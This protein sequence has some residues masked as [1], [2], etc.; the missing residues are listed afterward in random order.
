MVDDKWQAWTLR[1]HPEELLRYDKLKE[2]IGEQIR[3]EQDVNF[4][5]INPQGEMHHEDWLG[6]KLHIAI[7]LESAKQAF[8]LISPVLCKYPIAMR[9]LDLDVTENKT[10]QAGSTRFTIYLEKNNQATLTPEEAKNLIEEVTTVLTKNK[11][12]PGK[13]PV[14]DLKTFSPFF[15]IRNDKLPEFTLFKN[16][17]KWENTP[18]TRLTA[19]M[20]GECNN[21]MFMANPYTNIVLNHQTLSLT[22][23]FLSLPHTPS[24]D[25]RLTLTFTLL[26]YINKTIGLDALSDKKFIY[27][28]ISKNDGQLSCLN[29]L[30][31]PLTTQEVNNLKFAV[32]FLLFSRRLLLLPQDL[33]K[34]I[35]LDN[36][37]EEFNDL[38]DVVESTLKLNNLI[39]ASV[40]YSKWLSNNQEKWFVDF[41]KSQVSPELDETSF[42]NL[43]EN[44]AERGEPHAMMS[45]MIIY[46]RGELPNF[47][48]FPKQNFN[49]TSCINYNK[50]FELAQSL[51]GQKV[52]GE[53]INE[54]LI[55][56]IE[57]LRA[58]TPKP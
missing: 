10:H 5:L 45:L 48:S 56:H 3:Y 26:A 43:L 51:K 7:P 25:L 17:K 40:N 46:V 37:T 14:A 52:F 57:E 35:S 8:D 50:A 2:L 47:L 36:H 29:H 28:M 41:L 38:F 22:E 18:P 30:D 4:F 6:W 32:R 53:L 19:N 11:I 58:Q 21:P 27:D 55:N 33:I 49:L 31:A 24:D 16:F 20:V 23:H 15:S 13:P 44:M 9:V 42:I 54:R 12:A 39:G 34:E 1:Q